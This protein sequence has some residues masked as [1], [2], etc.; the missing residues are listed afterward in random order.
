MNKRIIAIAALFA[1]AFS[2]TAQA[3]N[4]IF[5]AKIDAKVENVKLTNHVDEPVRVVYHVNEGNDQATQA[6]R[7]IRNHL[8]ADPTAKIIVVTHA[9][10]VDF[11]LDGAVDKNGNNFEA[12]VQE[13]KGKGV[14]FRV[15]A[16][17]LKRRN[18]DP[19]KVIDEA[20]IVPSGVAEV[21]KLQFKEGYAYL[22]P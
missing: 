5:K 6:L 15:C 8:E 19:K 10:G 13:L 22:R 18:I 21:A 1:I 16:I 20:V 17:T 14:D 12:N 3:E 4:R 7:N 11:L 9:N 2:A